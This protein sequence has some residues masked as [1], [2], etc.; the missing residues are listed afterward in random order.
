MSNQPPPDDEPVV[1]QSTPGGSGDSPVE[2][3]KPAEPDFDPYRFG[4]PS[5]NPFGYPSSLPGQAPPTPPADSLGYPPPGSYPPP[6]AGPTQYPG[7]QYPGSQYPGAN[8]YPGNGQYPGDNQYPP[9]APYSPPGSYSP[10]G[11]GG[12]PPPGPYGAQY[13]APPNNP[14]PSPDT[15]NG[16]AVAGLVLGILAIVFFWVSFF[17]LPFIVLGIVFGVLGL[18]AAKRNGRGRAMA[19][20]GVTCALVGLVGATIFTVFLLHRVQT[21]SDRYGSGTH[22]Y[23]TCLND[24]K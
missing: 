21:C 17:D 13:P 2:L 10:Y 6:Y 16:K 11:S 12:Y 23:D 20:A 9:A 7:S 18:N 5:P 14:Y 4:R 22:A 24:G 8:Q 1:E 3:S 15:G 19:I